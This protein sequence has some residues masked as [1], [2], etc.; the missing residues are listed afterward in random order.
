MST[1]GQFQNSGARRCCEFWRISAS[2]SAF[3]FSVTGAPSLREEPLAVVLDER[4]STT[5][6]ARP[7][8]TAISKPATFVF[9]VIA[10]LIRA[11]LPSW[12][13]TDLV[14][15]AHIVFGEKNLPGQSVRR[16]S[17]CLR[18]RRD[19]AEWILELSR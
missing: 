8:T 14:N 3:A 2:K 13:L 9:V 11:T 12:P 4:T 16:G 17:V 15:K 6:N 19:Y 7:I 5:T 18:T 10:T 1:R